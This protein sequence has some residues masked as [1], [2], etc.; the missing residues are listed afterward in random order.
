MNNGLY[1][2]TTTCPVCS[3]DIQ[4]T[5]VKSN[6]CKMLGSDS[7]FCIYYE[8]VNPIFYDIWVC[9][10]CGYAAQR[11]KF[12]DISF[13]NAKKIREQ[14]TP[15]WNPRDFS[16]ERDIETALEA[17]KLALYELELLE[18]SKSS[19]FARI[20]LRIAWLYRINNKDK[21]NKNKENEFLNFALQHY[22]NAY[23]NERFP[24]GKF[25]EVTCTYLIGELYRRVGNPDESLKWFSRI[26]SSPEGRN[27]GRILE[28]TREQIQLVREQQLIRDQQLNSEQLSSIS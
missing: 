25:D 8:T 7:D 26:I 3:K 24:I 17:F 28:L 27:N 14:I 18:N 22:I 2:V 23:E 1:N 11:D 16:G 15:R 6:A 20:C 21:E 4:V 9:G 19:D 12:P 10:Y 5:K 13:K